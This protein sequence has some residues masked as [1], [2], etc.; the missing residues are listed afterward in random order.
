[1][2]RVLLMGLT[3]VGLAVG[4]DPIVPVDNATFRPTVL[5]HRGNSRGSGT[6]IASVDDESLIL[7]AAHVI[8]DSAQIFIEL[9]RYNL[10]VES[11]R[12]GTGWPRR[13]PAEL[14][15]KDV[16]ADVALLRIKGMVALP[17]VA[18][19]A[20]LTDPKPGDEVISL[21][22]DHAVKLSSWRTTL[23]GR[24][25]IDLEKG[26]G[27][28]LFLITAKP[29]DFGRSGGGLYNKDWGLVGVCVG[30]AE[31]Q[32]GRRDGIFASCLSLR[33]LIAKDEILDVIAK[34]DREHANR[35]AMNVRPTQVA[36]TQAAKPRPKP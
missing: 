24:A 31:F 14:V 9:H 17:Y 16:A 5:V 22:I 3:L 21:G 20:I 33:R 32:K 36:P 6:L 23:R 30:R 19:L 18:Q 2:R 10:G 28:R 13:V 8:D 1:M 7:T 25:I 11:S 34:S 4:A 29:P 12:S 15:D 27:E 35:E 26:G